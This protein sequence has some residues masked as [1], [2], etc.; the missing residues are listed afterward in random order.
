LNERLARNIPGRP[1]SVFPVDA[2]IRIPAGSPAIREALAQCIV[3]PPVSLQH[4]LLDEGDTDTVVHRAPSYDCFHTDRKDFPAA[5]FL[6]EL[7]QHLPDSRRRLIPT[8]GLYSLGSRHAL[9]GRSQGAAVPKE[10]REPALARREGG[11]S[12]HCPR[13]RLPSACA[14]RNSP[15][16]PIS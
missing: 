11:L 13:T 1:P 15:Q 7:L 5:E 6:V 4:L 16:F 2:S 14:H 12:L 8:C 9:P 3:R 10:R